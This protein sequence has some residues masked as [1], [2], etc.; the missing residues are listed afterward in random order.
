[1]TTP[2]N[3]LVCFFA[4]KYKTPRTKTPSKLGK[5]HPPC[6]PTCP[7]TELLHAPWTNGNIWRGANE[8]KLRL[9]R[10][11]IFPHK[12]WASL[13]R[14]MTTML[15]DNHKLIN[16]VDPDTALGAHREPAEESTLW[17]K[18]KLDILIASPLQRDPKQTYIGPM[19]HSQASAKYILGRKR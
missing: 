11:L 10:R 16:K 5:P 17:E 13:E 14:I 6:T 2:N 9:F 19:L 18:V 8:F 12:I 1:M 3:C 15:L 7:N 4:S